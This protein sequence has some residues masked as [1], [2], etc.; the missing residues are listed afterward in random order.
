MIFHD[1]EI[2]NCNDTKS[3]YSLY[4]QIP[5]SCCYLWQWNKW[6][7]CH[8]EFFFCTKSSSCF[9]LIIYRL[10]L[11]HNVSI[12]GIAPLAFKGIRASVD[13]QTKRPSSEFLK[14]F[15]LFRSFFY[16]FDM[17][18]YTWGKVVLDLNFLND[19][20]I[21]LLWL[22]GCGMVPLSSLPFILIWW[23]HHEL[24]TIVCKFQR[25]HSER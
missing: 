23:F 4:I 6:N 11:K 22:W 20:F 3:L 13:K 21:S 12:H 16:L 18:F 19:F 15:L 1:E 2:F 9:L 17:F 24:T 5:N 25:I 10:V 8:G 14:F 7:W